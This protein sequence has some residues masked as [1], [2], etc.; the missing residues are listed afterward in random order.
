M[1]TYKTSICGYIIIRK[2]DECGISISQHTFYST[3]RPWISTNSNVMKRSFGGGY[4]GG[5]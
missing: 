3:S 2:I 1:N 4:E 5:G